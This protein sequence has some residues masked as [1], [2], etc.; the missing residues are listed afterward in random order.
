MPAGF[1]TTGKKLEWREPG[2]P[3]GELNFSL[4]GG[5]LKF[6]L[7]IIREYCLVVFAPQ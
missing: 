3:G 7:P 5:R 6:A 2:S 1:V 4:E